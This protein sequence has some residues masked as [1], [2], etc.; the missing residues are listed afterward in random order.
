MLIARNIIV[1]AFLIRTECGVLFTN[2]V[3]HDMA[4]DIAGSVM[5]VFMCADDCLVTGKSFRG[6]FHSENLSL[7]G[8]QSV[9]TNIFWIEAHNVVM[10]LDL[11]E[12]AVSSEECVCCFAFIIERVRIA[13]DT[14]DKIEVSRDLFSVGTEYRLVGKLVVLH[15]QI[16]CRCIVIRVTNRYVF[17]CCHGTHLPFLLRHL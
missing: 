7:L 11:I 14:T 15:R 5:T 6:K 4:V 16:I 8:S 17:H 9:V 10:S 13:V 3:D 1:A 12:A 2:A